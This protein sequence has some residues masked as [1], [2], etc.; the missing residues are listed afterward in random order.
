MIG[1]SLAYRD[2]QMFTVPVGEWFRGELFGFTKNILL[3]KKALERNL[4]DPEPIRIML[5]DHRSG[6]AN[7][8]RQI[9][10]L[11]A[12]ELWFR[13][14]VDQRNLKPAPF[15]EMQFVREL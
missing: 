12:L 4:F 14:F 6:K 13:S 11:I 2:K 15:D 8:T 1:E 9:R 10:A 7:F 3:S 5:D